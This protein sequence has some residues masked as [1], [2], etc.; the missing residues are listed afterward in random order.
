M[1]CD[2]DFGEWNFSNSATVIAKLT[3]FLPSKMSTAQQIRF[4]KEN[5]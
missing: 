3:M 1:I 5:Y 4:Y 2:G